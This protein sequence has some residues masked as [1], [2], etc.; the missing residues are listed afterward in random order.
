MP[1]PR[2]KFIT[3]ARKPTKRASDRPTAIPKE[4]TRAQ[5]A[6]DKPLSAKRNN[7]YG[8]MG[9]NST[10]MPGFGLTPAATLKNFE[11]QSHHPTIVLAREI[12]TAPVRRN[13]WTWLKAPTAPQQWLE[14]CK[15]FLNPLRMEAVRDG[16]RAL[17]FESAFFE[18]VWYRKEGFSLVRKLKPLARY[19]QTT[20]SVDKG[21]N[22]VGLE[23]KGYGKDEK[24]VK[25]DLKESFIYRNEPTPERFYGQSRLENTL[26]DWGRSE[27][28]AERLAQY[29]RKI[30]GVIIQCHYPDGT[31]LDAN[32]AARPNFW[33]AQDLLDQ[34]SVGRS[35]AIPNKFSSF[36]SG[37]SGSI[38]PAAMEKA[39]LSA[40]K[41][42][43]VL[44][45]FEPGGADHIAG[46]LAILAYYDQLLFRGWGIPERSGLQST[47]GGIG[48]SDSEDMGDL[49]LTSAELVDADFAVAFSKGV[50]DDVLADNFGEEARGAVWVEPAPLADNSIQQA[51]TLVQALIANP[52]LASTV[53]G[54]IN[55]KKLIEE[56]GMPLA[57]TV[58]QGIQQAMQQPPQVQQM[59]MLSRL[60]ETLNSYNHVDRLAA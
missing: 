40:G 10:Q 28:I 57:E 26:K 44:S 21:G 50:I 35:V 34:V 48:T 25:L 53:A 52:L 29:V 47:K 14:L 30:S 3:L 59:A 5:G 37:D 54:K 58:S 13:T 32:G 6:T 24:P 60:L 11:L 20:I 51:F 9:G 39:L 38:T 18:K 46:F 2:H 45:A 33:L 56:S 42:D 12:V 8:Q 19:P 36:L 55:L 16:L 27:E 7:N 23:N 15:D 41:S 43:W 4:L 31:G 1:L 49:A 22:I 17:E